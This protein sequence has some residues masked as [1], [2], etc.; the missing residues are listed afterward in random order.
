MRVPRTPFAWEK[1]LLEPTQWPLQRIRSTL[2]A[3]AILSAWFPPPNP[4]PL[5]F[6]GVYWLSMALPTLAKR[7]ARRSIVRRYHL[8]RDVL[9]V[10][11]AAVWRVRRMF[12][13]ALLGLTL[14]VPFFA[15][16]AVSYPFLSYSARYWLTVAP[17]TENPRPGPALCGAMLVLHREAKLR[18]VVYHLP[19]GSIVFYLDER[20]GGISASFSPI[21]FQ[22]E[23]SYC[24]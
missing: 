13:A 22:G 4:L 21:P 16:Y 10:D 11:R 14:H 1:R 18:S 20:T 19:G 9:G 12:A 7:L 23:R 5:L 3:V 6:L 17:H 15:C 24:G 8:P 2:I